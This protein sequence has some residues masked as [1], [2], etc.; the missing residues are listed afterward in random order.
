MDRKIAEEFLDELFSSLE[1]Q[2]T[3]S[4][5]V[6]QFLKDQG[7]ATDEQLAPYMEQA[8]KA[9]NVRWRAARLRL[10]SLLSS[11][12]KSSE[13]ASAKG[14]QPEPEGQELQQKT[15]QKTSHREKPV[16][17][18]DS[19]KQNVP[20]PP[21]KKASESSPSE[22]EKP[23]VA[24]EDP[25]NA[26][27]SRRVAPQ[28]DTSKES[29]PSKDEAAKPTGQERSN[30]EVSRKTASPQDTSKESSQ[31]PGKKDAA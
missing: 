16:P 30:A 21:A 15:N 29:P 18:D 8:S 11:A 4:A 27:A 26:E 6:L 5:A 9:S 1:V 13:E 17:K 2:E 19:E 20:S 24:G 23:K 31:K 12:V 25:S 28:A 10:M 3:Q 7:N 14:S 22:D